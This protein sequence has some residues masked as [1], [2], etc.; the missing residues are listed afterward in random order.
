MTDDVELSV[1]EVHE[2]LVLLA[3]HQELLPVQL[4]VVV[5]V[6][7]VEDRLRPV[8]G[9][10]LGPGVDSLQH[11]VHGLQATAR[12][13][14]HTGHSAVSPPTSMMIPISCLSI[15]PELSVSYS[16]KHHSSFSSTV[17]RVYSGY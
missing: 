16:L 9:V 8:L 3:A 1:E 17:L 15:T 12:D 4:P 7:L 2:L 10:V 14:G 5:D 6:D 13:D 11:V